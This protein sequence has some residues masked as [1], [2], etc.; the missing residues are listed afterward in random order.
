MSPREISHPEAHET[1]V[2]RWD[3][4]LVAKS[5]RLTPTKDLKEVHIRLLDHQVTKLDNS[6][7]E[8]K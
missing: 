5:E 6:L 1:H 4:K 2:A 8:S 3:P 7:S